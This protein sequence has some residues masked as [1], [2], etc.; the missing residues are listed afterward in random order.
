[1]SIKYTQ[2]WPPKKINDETIYE[3]LAVDTESGA[4][5]SDVD[6]EDLEEE[7]EQQ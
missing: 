7:E 4:E 5:A 6:G 1:M 3:I 2:Q